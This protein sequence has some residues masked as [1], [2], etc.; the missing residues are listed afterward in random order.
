MTT[1]KFGYIA[2]W[3][4]GHGKIHLQGGMVAFAQSCEVIDEMNAA[5]ILGE[6]KVENGWHLTC[7]LSTG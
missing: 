2:N 6:D 3:W 7:P 4:T 5:A 1:F